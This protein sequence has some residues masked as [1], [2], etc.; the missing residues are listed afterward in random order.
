[1]I[2]LGNN[3]KDAI[4]DFEGIAT[5][6]TDYLFECRKILLESKELVNGKPVEG[7]WFDEP[8]LVEVENKKSVIGLIN[9]NREV[10]IL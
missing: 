3:Y 8:R 1:M 5:A 4:S 10:G 9:D 2:I 7:I 6:R